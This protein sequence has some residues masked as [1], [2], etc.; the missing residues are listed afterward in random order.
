[1]DLSLSLNPN[2]RIN[3]GVE[4]G[5]Y[6]APGVEIATESIAGC[7]CISIT[8]PAAM[9]R[10]I[11]RGLLIDYIAKAEPEHSQGILDEA[12]AELSEARAAV[13]R[14]AAEG[15]ACSR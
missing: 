9:V 7:D 5:R 15:K 2:A 1:M 3:A 12:A 8:C 11:V 4:L 14:R 6:P 10:D 13:A